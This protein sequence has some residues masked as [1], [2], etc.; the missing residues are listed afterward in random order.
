MSQCIILP[1]INCTISY[2]DTS[3][4]A[5]SKCHH[6]NVYSFTKHNNNN[7]LQLIEKIDTWRQRRPSGVQTE[8]TAIKLKAMPCT[9][10]AHKYWCHTYSNP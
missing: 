10:N 6:A 3:F 9:V 5:R 1:R 8:A 4:G 7:N 2:R